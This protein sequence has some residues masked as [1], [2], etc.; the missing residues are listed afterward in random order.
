V[1]IGRIVKEVVSSPENLECFSY[2][3]LISMLLEF[4]SPTHL[5]ALDPGDVFSPPLNSSVPSS[6]SLTGSK[7]SAKSAKLSAI[8]GAAVL[9]TALKTTKNETEFVE[10]LYFSP[11][12][13]SRTSFESFFMK[14]LIINGKG[15]LKL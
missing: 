11:L 10:F 9:A 14:N 15:A 13:R 2:P 3:E 4:T 1:N 8:R 7:T 6:T 12:V 5:K